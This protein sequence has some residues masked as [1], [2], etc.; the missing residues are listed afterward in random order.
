MPID[1]LLTP[2]DL[3]L[4]P[5]DAYW[6]QVANHE[7]SNAQFRLQIATTHAQF[8]HNRSAELTMTAHAQLL[9]SF[10]RAASFIRH[11]DPSQPTKQSFESTPLSLNVSTSLCP[12][13]C[14]LALVLRAAVSSFFSLSLLTHLSATPLALSSQS[15]LALLSHAFLSLLFLPLC[16]LFFSC[17]DSS[18]SLSSQLA[19]L[20]VLLIGDYMSTSAQTN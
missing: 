16:L 13:H 15:L 20:Q 4:T 10:N 7:N 9:P 8:A 17:S 18:L 14:L 12:S 6:L 1:L 11:S 19:C 2:I 3:L 5:I